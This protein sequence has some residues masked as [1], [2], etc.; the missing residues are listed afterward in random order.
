MKKELLIKYTLLILCVI[1]LISFGCP[2]NSLFGFA[3]PACGITRA[4]LCFLSGEI[5][6]A[7]RY[8]LFFPVIPFMVVLFACLDHFGEKERK[9]I[10]KWLVCLGV[11]IFI[12]QILRWNGLFIM[13]EGC[14]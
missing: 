8:H 12:Y 14:I 11:L 7:F 3:C 13:P 5:G 6:R 4:W 1:L 10:R 2:I 9:I